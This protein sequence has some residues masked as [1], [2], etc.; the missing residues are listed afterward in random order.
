MCRDALPV[1]AIMEV[2]SVAQALIFIRCPTP[3]KD[4]WRLRSLLLLL[5][6]L[7]LQ[8]LLLMLLLL[9][10]A[11]QLPLIL[12]YHWL[13]LLKGGGLHFGVRRRRSCQTLLSS[14]AQHDVVGHD[15]VGH[16]GT[17]SAGCPTLQGVLPQPSVC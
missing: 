7:L 6:L 2:N 10:L 3:T 11:L 5:L 9:L 14:H 16:H 12:L 1:L 13:L 8:L 17:V 15:V 4:C